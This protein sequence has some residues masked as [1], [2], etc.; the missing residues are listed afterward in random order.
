LSSGDT[1]IAKKRW[2]IKVSATDKGMV[3]QRAR[4][5]INSELPNY[6]FELLTSAKTN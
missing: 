5:T 6:V 3:Q 2:P 1:V 4:D